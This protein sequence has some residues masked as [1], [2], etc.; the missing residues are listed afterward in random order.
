VFLVDSSQGF[1][2]PSLL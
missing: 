1:G 2:G